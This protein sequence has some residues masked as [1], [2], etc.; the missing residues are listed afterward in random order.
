[1]KVLG[2]ENKNSGSNFHRIANPL[3]RLRDKIDLRLTEQATEKDFD[4]DVFYYHW[5]GID[6]LTLSLLKGKYG[7]KII[8]DIDDYWIYPDNHPRK[9]FQNENDVIKR[10]IQA[11]IVTT[12][13]T[14]L[15]DKARKYNNN[16]VVIPN[17]IEFGDFIEK[18]NEK[19]RVGFIGSESRVID[20]FELR[21][22]LEGMWGDKKVR[23]NVEFVVANYVKDS[24]F[25]KMDYILKDFSTIEPKPVDSYMSVYDDIDIVIGH[26]ADNEFNRCKSN[27]KLWEASSKSCLFVANEKMWMNKFVDAF[28]EDIPYLV[29][30]K[31]N[32]GYA[33]L[34]QTFIANRNTLKQLQRESYESNKRI[35]LVDKCDELRLK[36]I[37]VA[38]TLKDL[39]IDNLKLYGITYD[40]NQI[41]EFT[42]YRNKVKTI[43]EKSYLFEYNPI[44]DIIDN[45][46][47]EE[48]DY[49]GIFSWKLPFKTNL[50]KKFL[51]MMLL[52]NSN[53]D[54]YGLSVPLDEP[55][56]SFT[57]KNHPGFMNIFEK[58]CNKLNLVVK[59]PKNIVYSNQFIASKEVY[60]KYVNEVV[61]PTIELMET[62]FKDLV[63]KDSKYPGLGEKLKQYTGLDYYPFHTF[64]L[65]RLF[66]I[67][68]E[69]NKN[70]KFKQLI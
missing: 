44:I 26:L 58:I 51:N 61:K 34:L 37:Q 59:E 39:S 7:F 18:K 64:V 54:V 29:L 32:K 15:A 52:Q 62:E 35:S 56:L 50:T 42:E 10:I 60:T 69:N 12:T 63:W 22:I 48:N 24:A 55:Y 14:R 33:E 17:Y 67:W 3:K 9:I 21:G 25:K 49:I 41:T 70:I 16:V 27:L 13:C 40:D 57:E 5:G 45:H 47:F 2:I 36:V 20:Y 11:D 8:Y 31:N 53:F 66:S 46:K 4:V 38:L 65:E 28:V 43:E 68:L 1:M 23:D 19:I 6:T 30:T